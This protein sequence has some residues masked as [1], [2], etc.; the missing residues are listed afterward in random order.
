[1]Y[2]DTYPPL[3]YPNRRF[4]ALKSLMICL[5]I[6]PHPTPSAAPS[7]A[8]PDVLYCLYHFSF[9][10]ISW[11]WNPHMWLYTHWLLL[12]SNT[13]SFIHGFS[14][15]DKSRF[16]AL[17]VHGLDVSHLIHLLK[18]ILVAS[19]FC[20]LSKLPQASTCQVVVWICCQLLWIN[21]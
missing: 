18:D 11:G 15:L 8:T 7:L 21:T 20:Q 6:P 4:T 16:I 12:L 3:C 13:L 10:R 5:C 17:T 1:M 9:Y 14:Y 19:K 2:K